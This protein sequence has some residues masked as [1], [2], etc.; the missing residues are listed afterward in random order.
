MS[1]RSRITFAPDN[2]ESRIC[3][4]TGE[5]ARLHPEW[6]GSDRMLVVYQ[7]KV[8]DWG[9]ASIGVFGYEDG[10][11]PNEVVVDLLVACGAILDAHGIDP[12]TPARLVGQA[13]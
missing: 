3:D 5:L 1:E 9:E 10:D 13:G 12:N 11:M 2:R 6:K 8:D 4:A 7:G